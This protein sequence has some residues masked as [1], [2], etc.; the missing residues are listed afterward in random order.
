[1]RACTLKFVYNVVR[2]PYRRG[3][4]IHRRKNNCVSVLINFIQY[5]PI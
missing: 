1:M 5:Q 3:T 2:S 4:V